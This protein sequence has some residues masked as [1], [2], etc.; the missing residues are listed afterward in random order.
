MSSGSGPFPAG[1]VYCTGNIVLDILVKPVE[2]L[3][4]WGTTM[5][6]DSIAQHLGGNGAITSYALGKLGAPVRLAG[7]VGDDAFGEYVLKRLGSAGVDLS[8]VRVT[9][10]VQTAT[11]VGLINQHGE[12]LFLHV[13]GASDVMGPE[14]VS[15]DPGRMG[16][17]SYFHF[18]SMFHMPRMRAA[19]ADLLVRARQAGLV[20]SVDTMWDTAGR[21][22]EDFAGICPLIDLLFVNQDEA[23]M[24]A[25]SADP[26]EVGRFFRSRGIRIVILKMADHGCAVGA[27]GE[28][29]LVA[30][31]DAPAVDSTG[32]GDSFCGGFLAALLRGFSLREAA[33]FANAVAAH[34]IQQIGG[35]EGL[36]G[37]EETLAWMAGARCL[38]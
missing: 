13:L 17:F 26:G 10:G 6:V 16:G 19:A 24:L 12:R 20:T 1:G 15:F 7:A 18:A 34:C 3:P 23:R 38:T 2:A 33:R 9:P 37:F 35:T 27:P 25:G 21:W 32:A 4:S 5:W 8:D 31:Y 14:Q 30:A 36:A 28:E 11:T 22:M 29:C